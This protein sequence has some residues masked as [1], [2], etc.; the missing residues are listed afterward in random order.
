MLNN[1]TIANSLYS[2]LIIA[3]L[4]SIYEY[5]LFYF[6]LVPRL[7][8]RLSDIDSLTNNNMGA[9]TTTTP[10]NTN[11]KKNKLEDIPIFK[12]LIGRENKVVNKVNQF[13]V[14]AAVIML[15]FISFLIMVIYNYLLINKSKPSS[16]S[17]YVVIVTIVIIS[18]LQFMLY[19][20][21]NKYYYIVKN[22]LNDNKLSPDLLLNLYDHI[23]DNT[24][25]EDIKN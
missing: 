21:T 23:L 6:S 20:Y 22:L 2:T 7:K 13:T 25:S 4:F 14:F 16:Q 15:L 11:I 12:V 9:T 1:I 17:Y 3:L 24:D 8:L 10:A 18:I 5:V 19:T